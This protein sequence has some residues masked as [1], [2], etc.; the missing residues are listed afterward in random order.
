MHVLLLSMPD[1]F[2]HTPTIGMCMPNGALASLA[3]RHPSIG[4][5]RGLGLF[6]GLELVRSRET[7]EPLVPFNAAGVD[8][9][10]VAQL[11]KAALDAGLYL[12]VH[13]NVIILA[14]PLNIT[15]EELDEGLSILDE[16]LA[17][18]DEHTV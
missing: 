15:R 10:P 16:A 2:E 1:A 8:A 5:V 7:R 13:W 11:T 17:V 14:P 6:W 9:K 3:E 4:E 12:F 18:A